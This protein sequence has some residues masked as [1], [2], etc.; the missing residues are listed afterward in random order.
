[1]PGAGWAWYRCALG[2]AVFAAGEALLVWTNLARFGALEFG[3]RL[4]LSGFDMTYISRFRA[5]FDDEPFPAAV[6]DT[7]G[8]AFFVRR[9]NGY[10]DC[11]SDNLCA[12]QTSTPR[13]RLL[14]HYF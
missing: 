9:L 8:S 13:A 12:W 4:N 14:F 3:H 6:A 11:F 10:N 7:L 2:P 1:M 5:P